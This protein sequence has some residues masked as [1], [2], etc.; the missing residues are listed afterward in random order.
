MR[1]TR[2]EEH[3]SGSL[4]RGIVRRRRAVR[5]KRAQMPRPFAPVAVPP[6]AAAEGGGV[7]PLGRAHAAAPGAR[8]VPLGPRADAESLRRYVLEEACEVIDAIDSGDRA[9]LREELGDLLLQVVFLGE[10]VRNGGRVR[11][12]RHRARH[13]REAGAPPSRTCSPTSR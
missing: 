10:L 8:R 3:S 12:R 13:R 5:A 9:S 1:R 6:L 7:R 11:A 2:H 4:R